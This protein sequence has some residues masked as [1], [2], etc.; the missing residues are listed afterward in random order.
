MLVYIYQYTYHRAPTGYQVCDGSF[1][2]PDTAIT[3][4]N[5]TLVTRRSSG[6]TSNVTRALSALPQRYSFTGL[7]LSN[8][9]RVTVVLTWQNDAGVAATG[10]TTPVT[11]DLAPP[12]PTV[13]YV[14]SARFGKA[15]ST[16]Q[17][18]FQAQ[19]DLYLVLRTVTDASSVSPA[20]SCRGERLLVTQPNAACTATRQAVPATPWV[21]GSTPS[22]DAASLTVLP[23]AVAHGQQ[24]RVLVRV[25]DVLGNTAELYS[26]CV[27][28]DMTESQARFD[29]IVHPRLVVGD[30]E[31]QY[32]VEP[33]TADNTSQS[34][35]PSFGLSVLFHVEDD[36][37][38]T[39]W[40]SHCWSSTPYGACD[41]QRANGTHIL[42]MT[43][44]E[45]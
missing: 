29:A 9:D 43:R 42:R 35:A 36:F 39:E 2:D 45:N 28:I 37:A 27:V 32:L 19:S 21:S 20:F 23:C 5:L 10:V 7:S 30:D 33:E 11:V 34:P 40:F 14:S 1:T 17:L 24:Y 6:T 26:N 18:E 12:V 4:G 13:A 44:I 38:P 8:A 16:P 31:M 15:P 25:P 22:S 3:S 41:L